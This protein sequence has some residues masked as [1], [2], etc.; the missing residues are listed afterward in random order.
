MKIV[1]LDGGTTNPGD[2]SWEPIRA[3]G[4]LTVYDNTPA[5]LVVKRACN[6]DAVIL[7]RVIINKEVLDQLPNLKWI[8]MLATGYNAIDCETARARNIDVCNVPTYC[9]D[10]VAQQALSLLL[11]LCGN[12]QRYSDMVHA[13][14]WNGAVAASCGS[15][16]LIELAGKTL[17]IVGYGDIGQRMARLGA[18]LGMKVLLYSRTRKECPADYAWVELETLFRESD[19]VSLHCPLTDET[20]GLVG[21]KLLGLM[22]PTAFLINTAR[23]AVVD[24]AALAEALNTGKLAGA[25]LDVLDQEPPVPEHPLL[26]AKNCVITPHIAWSSKDARTRLISAVAENLRGFLTGSPKNVVN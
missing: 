18:A 19:A 20:R 26:H 6:A 15:V 12:A 5:E 2:V 7:N 25:G 1:I 23:G 3:L 21:Q 8:G 9:A 4:E 10:I 24:S 22:K 13:G 11:T 17:G 14:D 16:P